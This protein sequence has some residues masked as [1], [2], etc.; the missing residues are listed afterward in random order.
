MVTFLR[1]PAY[2][3]VGDPP[4]GKKKRKISLPSPFSFSSTS[5]YS[6]PTTPTQTGGAEAKKEAEET[7]YLRM[8]TD[9]AWDVGLT[10]LEND[11]KCPY[12]KDTARVFVPLELLALAQVGRNYHNEFL[13]YAKH[14]ELGNGDIVVLPDFC[15]PRQ[16]V[17]T[18]H[19]DVVPGECPG[20]R[21]VIHKHPDGVQSFSHTDDTYI[22]ANNVAS[23]LIEGG[24]IV[25]A[26]VKRKV[27]CGA[28]YWAK[29]TPIYYLKDPEKI[30]E[31]EKKARELFEEVKRKAESIYTS[32][33]H[34]I[35]R[36]IL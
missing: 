36:S 31:T 2:L 14:R 27:P 18:A 6:Y 26:V 8:D 30:G 33:Y 20:Y 7:K 19:V 28:F 29:A 16:R 34:Y 21:A 10:F 1:S 3:C 35:S 12:T 15:V 4:M 25:N 22:N 23:L 9:T 5:P 11:H 24:K 13:V 17:S 32:G